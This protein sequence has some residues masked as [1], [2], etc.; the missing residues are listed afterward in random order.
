[1]AFFGAETCP[2]R[3]FTWEVLSDFDGAMP[4]NETVADFERE[5]PAACKRL[6]DGGGFYRLWPLVSFNAAE[7]RLSRY[8][9]AFTERGA[10]SGSRR[11]P[12]PPQIWLYSAADAAATEIP[13]DDAGE[14]SGSFWCHYLAEGTLY[15]VVFFEGRF[16]HWSEETVAGCSAEWL[17]SRLERFRK[18]LAQDPLFS[19]GI[20]AEVE[21]T[22][23][24]F[25]DR[26][27]ALLFR[28]ASRDP[29]W[30][31][32]S[33]SRERNRG[34]VGNLAF[35]LVSTFLLLLAVLFWPGK[36]ADPVDAAPVSLLPPPPLV[37][38]LEP[39]EDGGILAEK[40]SLPICALSE[41]RLKGVVSGKLAIV[42][43][44]GNSRNLVPGDSLGTFRLHRVERDRIE[45]VCKDSLL[46]RLVEW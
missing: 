46:E 18:F 6:R 16:C 1:M 40:N 25:D 2:A 10:C 20:I 24:N 23:G 43:E 32:V 12:L 38:T 39:E 8:L 45:L 30:R 29:F 37:E 33:L 27:K 44:S 19:R 3:L 36:M 9:V 21:L 31:G 17:S 14:W 26:A 13:S 7:G 41:F 11:R 34:A 22:P 15:L 5:F 35:P 42:S 28:C 4:L